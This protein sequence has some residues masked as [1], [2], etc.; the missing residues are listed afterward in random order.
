MILMKKIVFSLILMTV[1]ISYAKENSPYYSESTQKIFENY[2]GEWNV[3]YANRT[4]KGTP[5][6]GRGVSV[7]TLTMGKTILQFENKLNFELGDIISYYIIG[8]DKNIQKY[9]FLTYDNASETPALLWGEYNKDKKMFEFKNYKGI[10]ANGDMR[11]V[12]KFARED[13][14]LINSYIITDG[15]ENVSLDMALIKK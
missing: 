10:P 1:F 6:G 15:E 9:Y 14:I 3:I 4:D 2:I 7:S 12:I 5:A 8:Y 13:K 11:L